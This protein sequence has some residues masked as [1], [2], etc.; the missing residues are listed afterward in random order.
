[1]NSNS[2][3][4]PVR[5]F[6]VLLFTTFVVS[7]SYCEDLVAAKADEYLSRYAKQGRFSGAVLIAKDGKVLFRKAYGMADIEN[8]VPNTP[9]T[10][11]RIGS[12]TKSFTAL[13]IL[14]IQAQGKLSVTDKVVDYLPEFPAAW[15]EITIHHLMTH[16]SGIPDYSRRALG[17]KEAFALNEP[18]VTKPGETL[19]YSNFGYILLGQIIEKTSGTK[20]DE[21]L[22]ANVLKPLAMTHTAFDRNRAIVAHR[23]RG[24]VFDGAGVANALM[25][26]MQGAGPAGALHSTLDD[27]YLYDQAFYG[28]TVITRKIAQQLFRGNADWNMP[29]PFNMPGAKYA[30]G[31]LVDEQAKHPYTRHGGWVDG[32]VSELIRFPQDHATIIL[33]C[34]IES[35]LHMPII[36]DLTAILFAEPYELPREHKMA[37]LNT[38]LVNRYVG[39]YS[40]DGMP[41][42]KVAFRD[43]RLFLQVPGQPDFEMIA[44][45]DDA[46]FF[47]GA[48]ASTS[49][50]LDE[51]KQAKTLQIDA[52]E[53]HITAQRTGK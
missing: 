53:M 48:E 6:A 32:F 38:E 8:S 40:A 13:A 41:P 2:F 26:E 42:L 46:F 9:E 50:I 39:D 28:S 51:S 5:W 19:K 36:R 24:Y 44:E 33:L 21:Y 22:A 23:A 49:F 43:G 25:P 20:Y 45:A 29:Y 27:L 3:R 1:M 31:W 30:Y 15:Q 18:L 16:T 37:H 47:M 14:Q 34:N 17:I 52:P 12:I 10:V 4:V 11:F 7:T 35:P